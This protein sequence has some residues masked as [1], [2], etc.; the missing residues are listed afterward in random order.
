MYLNLVAETGIPGALLFMGILASTLRHAA[1][2]ER[3]LR[4]VMQVEAE[5]LRILRFGL[6]AYLI[7][8]IFGTFHRISFPYLYLAILWSAATIFEGLLTSSATERGPGAVAPSQQRKLRGTPFRRGRF[9][10][11]HTV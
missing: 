6:V 7:A 9:G 3:K 10:R 1:G 8:A 2:V 4:S 5:Q 11:P